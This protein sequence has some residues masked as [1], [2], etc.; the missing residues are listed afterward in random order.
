MSEGLEQ[1]KQ[2]IAEVEQAISQDEECMCTDSNLLQWSLLTF[3]NSFPGFH[4]VN[5]DCLSMLLLV[6]ETELENAGLAIQLEELEKQAVIQNQTLEA[7][8]A[9][10]A[11][12]T[13]ADCHKISALQWKVEQLN[14]ISQLQEQR[15]HQQH[16]QQS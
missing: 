7:V 2:S 8:I 5:E 13:T 15:L 3:V 16:Q 1:T 14:A 12:D 11:A 6:E 4:M 9:S 10:A